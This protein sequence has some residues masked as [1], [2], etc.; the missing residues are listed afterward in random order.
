MVIIQGIFLIICRLKSMLT[1]LSIDLPPTAYCL[2]FNYPPAMAPTT[3]NGSSPAKTFSGSS[4]T[5]GDS[6]RSSPQAK[7]LTKGRRAL[8]SC[9]RM[10]PLSIG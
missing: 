5:V 4:V 1:T 9:C 6:E 7:Y 10:V 8:V 2:L 3:K